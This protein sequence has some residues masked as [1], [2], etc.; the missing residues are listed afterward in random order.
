MYAPYTVRNVLRKRG[1]VTDIWGANVLMF[2]L[3]MGV[4]MHNLEKKRHL[5]KPY[6]RYPLE[7][8]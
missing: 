8:V 1:W 5:L 2:S 6:I 3:S 7:K 4:M